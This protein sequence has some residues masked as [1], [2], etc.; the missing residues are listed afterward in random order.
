MSKF[1][2]NK[3]RSVLISKSGAITGKLRGLLKSRPDTSRL[4]G[5]LK[6]TSSTITV[7]SIL[8]AGKIQNVGAKLG[9]RKLAACTSGVALL[10]TFV[11]VGT[12]VF[13][14]SGFAAS[15]GAGDSE[16]AKDAAATVDPAVVIEQIEAN[17]T[18]DYPGVDIVIDED[19]VPLTAEVTPADEDNPAYYDTLA[20]TLIDTGLI[21]ASAYAVKVDGE[22][23]A[24]VAS[25]TEADAILGEIKDK[26][27]VEDDTWTGD[28][29]EDI[30]VENVQVDLDAL[31]TTAAAVDYLLTGGAEEEVYT[32][33]DGDTIWGISIELGVSIDEIED[34]NPDYDVEKIHTGDEIKLTKV[35][36]FIHYET[37]GVVETKE[38]IDYKITEEETDSLYE[39][40]KEI[41]QKG[42]EGERL[43]KIQKVYDNGVLV[44]TQELS[45]K[46]LKKPVE[47]IVQVGTKERKVEQPTTASG[48]TSKKSTVKKSSSGNAS[49]YYDVSGGS[50]IIADAKKFLGL[51]YKRGGSTPSGFD[52]SG[53]TSYIYRLNGKSIP[54]TASGQSSAG[55]YIPLSSAKPGDIVCFGKRGSS[56][57]VGIYLGGNKYIHS[58][59]TGQKIRIQSF[60]SA[61][62]SFAVRF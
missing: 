16:E 54:R 1:D 45:S 3:L 12:F 55:K 59:Y 10:T 52:C 46:T 11:L 32:V 56:Y 35:T 29:K 24:S 34:S 9:R 2:A 4:I 40:E 22:V 17:V 23:L 44:D 26:F 20:S 61:R 8:I 27:A 37:T 41:K 25:R 15:S 49:V 36:P 57:H 42:V 13:S 48:S 5:F 14:G 6:V 60:A 47:K 31:T 51:P 7:R 18:K 62:P 39:G 50:G 21:K 28:F 58:P 19:A 33:R 38:V 43:V 53:F 30:I